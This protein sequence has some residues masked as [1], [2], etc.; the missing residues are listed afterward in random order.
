MKLSRQI[1]TVS[2]IANVFIQ[3]ATVSTGAG[4]A[5]IIASSVSFTWLQDIQ[6]A[7]STGTCTSG[8]LGTFSSATLTQ[9][10]SSNALGWYQFGIPNG[11]LAAGT[12]SLIHI[13]G[14]PSMAP[15]PIE[16]ELTK[17][18]NQQYASSTVFLAHTST[19]PA[20]IVQI[21]GQNAVTS[22]AGTLNVSTQAV[23]KSGYIVNVS[24]WANS[25]VVATSSGVVD[26]NLVNIW[27]KS[28]V[29]SSAGVLN[30]STQ[31]ID[32]TGYSL[33]ANQVV[34]S[35]TG[36]VGSVLGT[37]NV[38]VIQIQGQ[39]A[40]TS[41]A[42]VLNVSTQAIDKTGYTVSTVQDKTGYNATTTVN[43][44]KTGYS[45]TAAEEAAIAGTILTT[46][47]PEAYRSSSAVGSIM[48]LQYEILA[49]LTE[50]GNSGTT[51]T[52]NSITSHAAA[53]L[54]YG[55]DSSTTP[56]P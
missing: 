44:D 33:A 34:S 20:N 27:N 16:M 2:Q 37:T 53:S 32:K 47:Q 42:G 9:V 30:V 17:T 10:S 3:D 41:S 26:V 12:C 29:T 35:V 14:A 19:S 43:L 40:V 49:N 4:L 24:S 46:T 11:A 50:F 45:L 23:D 55:Y 21:Q 6:A 15:L 38:N 1:G 39:N 56:S 5:N 48:Q 31:A 8:T 25:S 7:I 54:T 36:S 18:N 52:L 22:S 28:A 51:R 13:Y